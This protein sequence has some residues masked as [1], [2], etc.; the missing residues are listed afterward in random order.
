MQSLLLMALE[1]IS[2]M[3]ASLSNNLKDPGI[4]FTETT[5]PSELIL[6]T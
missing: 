3:S 4:Y 6:L 5:Y 1:E 2:L